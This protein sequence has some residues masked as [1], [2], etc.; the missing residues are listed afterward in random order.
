MR[1]LFYKGSRQFLVAG[2]VNVSTNQCFFYFASFTVT[3]LRCYYFWFWA[4]YVITKSLSYITVKKGFFSS[5]CISM[6]M[7]CKRWMCA[8][9]WMQ[10]HWEMRHL[11]SSQWWTV[12]NARHNSP[13]YVFRLIYTSVLLSFISRL[14][15]QRCNTS[16]V[17]I[18]TVSH[19]DLRKFFSCSSA[20][21]W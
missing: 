19:K 9:L 8:S 13:R 21:A 12:V 3:L 6:H 20:V 18:S 4:L 15:L 16:H 14:L 11:L 7:L 1:R 10:V 2:F 5:L 17:N